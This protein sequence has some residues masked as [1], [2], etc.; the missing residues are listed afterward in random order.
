MHLFAQLPRL[1]DEVQAGVDLDD[2]LVAF[3]LL[4]G[5]DLAVDDLTQHGVAAVVL[6]YF[7]GVFFAVRVGDGVDYS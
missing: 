7:E 3:E 1:E 2:E 5:A 6:D 4:L